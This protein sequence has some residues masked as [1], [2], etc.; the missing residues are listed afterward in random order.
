[1]RI[2]CLLAVLFAV[3]FAVGLDAS[4]PDTRPVEG[5]RDNT[6]RSYAL[7]GARV[8]IAPGQVLEQATIVI[9]DGTITD[10][11]RDA[12]VPPDAR[13]RPL[14]GKTIYAGL[15]DAHSEMRILG[16]DDL[17]GTPHWNGRI[18]PQRESSAH[19]KGVAATNKKLRSQGIAAQLV[20]PASGIVKGTSSIVLTS[21]EP[22]YS[23]ILKPRVALHVRLT[24]SR[25]R[26]RAYP[27]SPMGAVALARQ[28]MYDAQ[29]YRQAWAAYRS[30][31]TL[32]RPE[33]N[34]ALETLQH[35]PESDSLIVI[36]AANELYFLRA[37]RFAREFGLNILVRG[38]GNEYRRLDAIKNTGRGVLVPVNFPNPPNVSTAETAVSVSLE[39]LLHWDLAPE[40]PARLEAAGVRFA[41]TSA[42]LKDRGTFLA[43]VRRA[44]ARGLSP[45][46][47]LRSVT[48]TPA[49]LLQVDDVLG[50]IE[51]GKLAN[52]VV[53][54]GDLFDPK[55]KVVETWVRGRRYDVAAVPERDVRG[56]WL[57]R[58]KDS[59]TGPRE[60]SLALTGQPKR[61][62]G[63]LKIGDQVAGANEKK[64][65]E[66]LIRVGL[67]DSRFSCSFAGRLFDRTGVVRLTAI[68]SFPDSGIPT[69]LGQV[70]WPD[71]T[72]TEITAERS[73]G[74]DRKEQAQE[75]IT[76]GARIPPPK[77]TPAEESG[78]DEEPDRTKQLASF[79]VNYP[80]G[81]FGLSVP[82]EAA[83]VLFRNATIWT[84]GP[85]GLLQNASLLIANG[86][87]RAVGTDLAAP[88]DAIV[89]DA[90]GKHL[91]PGIIDCHSH[92][93]TDGGVNESGQA[94]TAEV[95]IGD[96][97]NPDDISVY[98]QLAGGVTSSNILHGSANPIGGQNQVIKLR[99]GAL[100]EEMKF[101]EA[102]A[103]IKFAL[104]ENV[105]RA[106][107]NEPSDRYPQSRMGVEQIMR[108]AFYAAQD[109]ADRWAEWRESHQGTPPRRD[110]E[111]EALS[112]VVA[113]QRWV[114]CHS[115]RQ[116]EILALMRTMDAFGIQIGT[117]Q[118]ILEG[119]KVADEMARH[120]AMGSA[121]SDWWAYKVEVYDAIPYAG[122]L[123]QQAG[124]VVS[125]NSDDSELGR[126]LNHEAA[127]AVKYGGVPPEEALKFVT[128]NPARQLRIDQYVGSLEKG[129]HADVVVWSGP[130]LSIRSR[131]EQ[132]WIDGRKYFD[133]VDDRRQSEVVAEQRNV[134]VQKILA[135]GESMRAPGKNSKVDEE[136]WPREDVFCKCRE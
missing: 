120:G 23:S 93:A 53:T 7:T 63:K 121:F 112:E 45:A 84:C 81:A 76:I 131:C 54:D 78:N 87:I 41:L 123:M 118:H 110:L 79:A 129:K 88:P 96:F 11:R 46:G 80:L 40:N 12:A 56:T 133:R 128:L 52:L 15:L 119:Y 59:D 20:A 126:H 69:W 102:P 70:T 91:T 97:I 33:R 25:S 125:Y 58:L 64:T 101:A 74:P 22:N 103:G 1:M 17:G 26:D 92:M 39:E 48:T 85:D 109:Y 100:P 28:S 21:D 38:S 18:T 115:Y 60:F 51:P 117:F 50:T 134:L 61:L 72:R 124:V 27:N 82:P 104:G 105:T 6:P 127:K 2:R 42:G 32:P 36:D 99:W 136:L 30:S 90:S 14:E 10:V 5:L 68:L 31:R 9:R 98:R 107:W 43:K 83:T 55:T 116:D 66:K 65:T 47:A 95:R 111:L 8:V 49:E 71:G 13:V 44:V 29:W 135:S 130:P 62:A 19:Y 75:V 67:R 106:N 122:A 89:V 108:D 94:I 16:S 86:E 132:T 35:Y 57:V 37:D 73:S 114:H 34:D 3:S 77:N 113:G 24:V 4:P